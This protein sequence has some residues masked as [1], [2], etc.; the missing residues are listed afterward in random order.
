VTTLRR[1]KFCK[2]IFSRMVFGRIA[3]ST[4]DGI[5]QNDDITQNSIQLKLH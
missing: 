2:M 3:L 1:M 5:V 4:A